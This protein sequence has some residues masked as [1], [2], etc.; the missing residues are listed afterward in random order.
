MIDPS[1]GGTMRRFATI[2]VAAVIFVSLGAPIAQ[3][4]P[5]HCV[6]Q[7]HRGACYEIVWVDGEEGRM[8]FAQAGRQLPGTPSAEVTSFYVV[9]PQTEVSQATLPFPHDH[10][11]AGL[12]GSDAFS[13]F[14][15]GYLVL[16]SPEGLASGACVPTSLEYG[17]A[18]LPL[19][20]TVNGQELTTVEPIESALDSGL[21]VLLDP[22]AE[23]IGTI[24]PAT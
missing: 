16:C 14:L 22:E 23:L 15:H 18:T 6:E 5:V 19:A 9:A 8:T 4:A 11:V 17:G 24:N 21:V 12:P 2:T 7:T 13:V 20:T 1:R 10:V 3:A